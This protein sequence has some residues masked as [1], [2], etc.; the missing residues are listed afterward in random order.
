MIV[1][2]GQLRLKPDTLE[3][4]RPH[5]AAM[6]AATRAEPGCLAYSY[7]IDLIEPRVVRVFELWHSWGDLERHF[8]SPHLLAWRAR[9]AEIGIEGRE[10]TAYEAREPRP[11]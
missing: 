2:A 3:R 5:M 1:V 7:G 10:L 9:L 8:A 6:I 4:L 11:V